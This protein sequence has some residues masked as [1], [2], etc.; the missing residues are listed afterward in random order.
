MKAP[1]LSSLR[2][3][4][5]FARGDDHGAESPGAARDASVAL[6]AAG[7]RE[8]GAP[9]AALVGWGV[10]GLVDLAMIAARATGTSPALRIGE[11]YVLELGNA[12]ALGLVSAA[13]ILG[14]RP[15]KRAV[16]APERRWLDRLA[17]FGAMLLAAAVVGFRFLLHDFDAFAHRKIEDYHVHA[18][19]IRTI[20]VLLLVV[21]VGSTAAFSELF[22]GSWR[23]W[24]GVALG[25]AL[26]LANYFYLVGDYFSAH[27]A[28]AWMASIL[29]AGALMGI[30]LPAIPRRV[31]R[32]LLGLA[33]GPALCAIAVAPP[34]GIAARML[35]TH[36]DP[37]ALLL[38]ARGFH[39][40]YGKAVVPP[41]QEEWFK[42]RATAPPIPSHADPAAAQRAI[43]LMLTIDCLRGDKFEMQQYERYFPEM[44]KLRENS[45]HFTQAE[46]PGTQTV[47]TLTT[48][49]T[50]KYFSQLLWRPRKAGDFL[51]WAAADPTVRFPGLLDTQGIP[52]T[53]VE[54]GMWLTPQSGVVGGF[55]SSVDLQAGKRYDDYA[56]AR[57]VAKVVIDRL[58]SDDAAGPFFVFAHFMDAH[59][60]YRDI[61]PGGSRQVRYWREIKAID[62]EIGR[63]LRRVNELGLADR[64]TVIVSADHGEAFGEHGINYHGESV[65]QELASVPL[66]IAGPGYPARKVDTLVSTIDLGPTILD[67]FGVAT[68]GYMMGQ[69]LMDVLKGGEGHFTRPV[70]IENRLRQ[71]M[72]FPD[73]IKVSRDLHFGDGDAFD[74]RSDPL[75]LDNRIDDPTFDVRP[76]FALLKEFFDAHTLRSKTYRPPYRR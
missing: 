20:C 33:V 54:A 32:G 23:R 51:P 13:L 7:S 1:F 56:R 36:T 76:R 61:G 46:S 37:F 28:F 39:G 63:I 69:S 16:I 11:A 15:L 29:V 49:F 74:L 68:P 8:L 41:E 12:T 52:S 57:D 73:G 65:F 2:I 31:R 22:R 71:T 62:T 34:P 53:Y 9:A 6:G 45:V 5:L 47:Y 48:W 70:V 4:D 27:F 18:W 43:V 19:T 14:W 66:L 75:E 60:P 38:I 10:V 3:K 44:A 40:H 59:P 24:V 30:R 58:E 35:A 21:F 42:P 72:L 17:D 50:G 64:T 55:T 67:T 26:A 25:L